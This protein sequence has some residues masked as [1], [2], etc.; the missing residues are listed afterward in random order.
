[1]HSSA[2]ASESRT[3]QLERI[4]NRIL[5]EQMVGIPILNPKLEVKTLGYQEFEGREMCILITP[6]LMLV[7]MLPKEGDDWEAMDIGKKIPRKFPSRTLKFMVNEFEEI[8]ICQTHSLYSPMGEFTNQ[9][10]AEAAANS[11][12][13]TLFI[14]A[15]EDAPVEL[16]AEDAAR[17]IRGEGDEEYEI[18]LNDFARVEPSDRPEVPAAEE[19]TRT[20]LK[21][22]IEQPM[23]RRNLLRGKF[24]KG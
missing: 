9:E 13:E 16:D 18:N 8:G 15:D 6:W 22:R 24:L 21:E 5:V 11:F 2:E 14:S 23:S 20:S 19:E 4:F 12:L 1:M 10:H 7:M 17:L 3:E